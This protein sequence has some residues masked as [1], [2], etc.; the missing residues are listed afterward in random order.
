MKAGGLAWPGGRAY[1]RPVPGSRLAL[2]LAALVAA[3]PAGAYD[4][5]ED[6]PPAD[7]SR[8]LT[9]TAFGG[10][11]FAS[12]GGDH[13][14]APFAGGEV[15]WAFD[16]IELGLQGQAARLRTGPADWSPIA[17]L[18]L[19]QRFETRR[20]LDASLSFGAG[21]AREARWHPWFQVALGGR[22]DL[23]PIFATAEIAFEQSDLIR[24]LVGL[25]TRL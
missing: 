22:M 24:A 9:L 14:N 15:A 20:G 7:R 25:G 21:A 1:P 12:G 10:S 11:L 2:I 3:T 23:G 8:R 16:S 13:V 17:L 4:P 6:P 5:F 18:R 19:T